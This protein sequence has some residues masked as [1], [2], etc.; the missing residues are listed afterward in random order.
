MGAEQSNTQVGTVVILAKE[1]LTGK[2]ARLLELVNDSGTAK[3]QLPDA[4]DD[5]VPFVCIEGGA[6]GQR[7]TAQPLEP[8]RNVRVRLKGTCNPGD[9]LCLADGEGTAA[10]KGMVRALPSAAGTYVCFAI[11]EET[12]ADGQLVKL[13]YTGRESVTVS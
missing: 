10:D 9:R 6:A 7:V 12:G 5:I 3:V 13:R 11:A 8:G 2:E 1:D 4:N